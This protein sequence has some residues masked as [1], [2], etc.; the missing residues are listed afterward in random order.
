MAN[1]G[2]MTVGTNQAPADR[3]LLRVDEADV[4]YLWKGDLT[5]LASV[6]VS[7]IVFA[8]GTELTTGA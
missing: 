5:E 4:L 6:K 1:F 2:I 7:K 3:V 8:D